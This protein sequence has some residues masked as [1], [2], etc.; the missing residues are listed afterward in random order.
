[1]MQAPPRKTPASMKSPFTLSVKI[2]STTTSRWIKSAT[3]N[4][5]WKRLLCRSASSPSFP[6]ASP[7]TPAARQA[8]PQG[9]S[10]ALAGGTC[11]SSSAEHCSFRTSRIHA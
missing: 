9:C 4:V 5:V 7:E 10:Q 8:G 3:A 11:D 6:E 1:M 2:V